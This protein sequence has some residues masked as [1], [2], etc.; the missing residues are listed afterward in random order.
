MNKKLSTFFLEKEFENNLIIKKE[1][2]GTTVVLY[3]ICKIKYFINLLFAE[4]SL[5]IYFFSL[6]F[7]MKY[8]LIYVTENIFFKNLVKRCVYFLLFRSHTCF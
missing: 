6:T 2:F 5:F 7:A 3:I 4:Y 8:L 1:P